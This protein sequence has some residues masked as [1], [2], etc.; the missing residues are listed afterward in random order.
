LRLSDGATINEI[1]TSAMGADTW[2]HLTDSTFTIA[3]LGTSGVG[4]YIHIVKQGTPG[5]LS[6]SS[7]LI[8]VYY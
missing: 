1:T 8:A 7:P 3:T 2:T 4:A 5:A 6:L